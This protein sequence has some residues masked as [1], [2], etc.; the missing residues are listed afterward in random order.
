MKIIKE[1]INETLEIFFA[2]IVLIIVVATGFGS[3]I[4][5]VF[6]FCIHWSLSLLGLFLFSAWIAFM[7]I[8]DKKL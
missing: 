8:T 7:K 2:L 3:A 6:G 1:Y 4:L 5:I